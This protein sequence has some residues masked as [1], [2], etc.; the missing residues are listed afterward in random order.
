[1]LLKSYSFDG[2]NSSNLRFYNDIWR[3]IQ[4]LKGYFYKF[5]GIMTDE[6]IQAT[7]IHTLNHYDKNKASLNVYIKSLARV[8]TKNPYK[9]ITV[10]FLEQ[11]LS[12]DKN[13][14]PD[15]KPSTRVHKTKEDD[16][17]DELIKGIDYEQNLR[18]DV[19]Q[20]ALEFMDK[21]VLLCSALI[22]HDTST[23][24]Y[25]EV[26]IQSCMKIARKYDDFNSCCIN[27]FYEYEDLFNWFIDLDSNNEGDVWKET[28]Y[29]T[30]FSNMSKRIKFIN[31]ETYD[32]VSDA[33]KED[34]VLKG[35]LGDKRIVR[36]SY[37]DLWNKF[38]DLIDSNE[39]NEL[40]FS[41]DNS[42]I[43]KTFGG[44]IS[45]LNVDLYNEYDLVKQ[46]IITNLICDTGGRLINV[47]SENVYLLCNDSCSELNN[48]IRV[49]RGLEIKFKYEDITDGI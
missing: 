6:A 44:S 33:D 25:P 47:G 42:Y 49:V 2:D 27:L 29:L 48:K 14:K 43:I 20:V 41:I 39:I 4:G 34:W 28:D 21:F 17:T 24:Y 45:V 30:I 32:V 26:F 1:M 12:N 11:T 3:E 46:E 7:F 13:E 16:F 22:R 18:R 10:D 9:E 35:K 19:I 38:C 23:I 8:I 36:V 15:T 31:K 5:S 40:K 37:I